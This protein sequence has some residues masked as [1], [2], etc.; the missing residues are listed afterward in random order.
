MNRRGGPN[1]RF[2]G[3]LLPTAV[4]A[5][6]IATPTVTV[7]IPIQVLAEPSDWEFQCF[8]FAEN[9]CQ[10]FESTFDKDLANRARGQ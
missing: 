6:V 9:S 2:G 3:G 4:D 8:W 10:Q 5:A 1:G 7:V